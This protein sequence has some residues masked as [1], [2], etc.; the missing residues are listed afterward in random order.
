MQSM[1]LMSLMRSTPPFWMLRSSGD[2]RPATQGP[3]TDRKLPP[4]N[5]GLHARWKRANGGGRHDDN[6]TVRTRNAANDP[7]RM[8]HPLISAVRSNRPPRRHVIQGVQLRRTD[9]Q[10]A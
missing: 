2:I 5:L 3:L 7:A 6:R 9:D 10:R 4:P 1:L 8:R